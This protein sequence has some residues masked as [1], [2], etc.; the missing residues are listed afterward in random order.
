[1]HQKM[2]TLKLTLI[3]CAAVLVTGCATLEEASTS[4]SCM[5]SRVT[6]SADASCG[7]GGAG[8]APATATGSQ[9][10]R[11]ERLQAALDQETQQAR[12]AQ[13]QAVS[14]MQGL[15]PGQRAMA[16]PVKLLD[17]NIS[18]KQSGGE[19][20]MRSFSSVTVDMP[21]A[22]KGRPEYTRAMD[23]LKDLANQLAD[24]RGSS[25]IV[26]NQAES[27]IKARRVNT[28]TGV[29]QTSGGKPVSV[30][31]TIDRTLPAGIERYT[32]QAGE[33]RGQL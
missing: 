14:A 32:I 21:L 1:M 31:K 7:G 22:A 18:D 6:N 12:A 17:I 25:S 10:D 26:V 8:T 27:D 4:F 20:K 5:L 33:I 23:T 29:T 28:A 13:V 9:A 2:R 19:R 30:Q 15:P 16:G 11:F 3:S 24:N